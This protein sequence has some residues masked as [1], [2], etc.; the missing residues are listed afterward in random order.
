M[1]SDRPSLD[2]LEE[3]AWLILLDVDNL[4]ADVEERGIPDSQWAC[5]ELEQA[6]FRL[7]TLISAAAQVDPRDELPEDGGRA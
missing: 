5:D 7:R 6:V 1:A 4:V 3:R 2:E